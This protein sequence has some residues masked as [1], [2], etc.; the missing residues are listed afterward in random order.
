MREHLRCGGFVSG[1]R[2]PG[3]RELASA[4]GVPRYALRGALQQLQTEGILTRQPQSGTFL[5]VIP[6]PLSRGARIALISPLRTMEGT[7]PSADLSWLHRVISAI[8]RTARPAGAEIFVLDQSDVATNNCSIL[9][10]TKHAA[11][12]GAAAAILLHPTGTKHKIAA[13]L[14]YLHD[15]HV[16][17][18]IVSARN[19]AGLASQVYFD[20]GWGAHLAV[21][22][23]IENSH[24]RIGFAG[25]ADGHEWV[26]E[27][28]EGYM[29]ALAA[30]G[31]S[32][33][34]AWMWFP[35][36]GEKTPTAT[37]GCSAFHR[38]KSL[39]E[40][41]RPT[42]IVA[43]NDIVALGFLEAARA[44]GFGIPEDVSVVGFDNDHAA[45]TAGLTTIERPVEALGEAVARATLERLAAVERDATISLRLKPVLIPR[46]TVGPPK[47]NSQKD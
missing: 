16:H 34:A 18:V 22:H 6:L 43:A 21:R 31:L 13:A 1:Q 8:E 5:N 15:N 14:A 30:S 12:A 45:L 19:Y 27:R 32:T 17:P 24:V 20:S 38:W 29:N 46:R 2:L 3:E 47:E 25:A 39:K 44:G 28:R 23:L 40:H 7:D 26:N 4:L 11:A 33:T 37:D 41:S 10:L 42:G 35:D 9:D 36:H